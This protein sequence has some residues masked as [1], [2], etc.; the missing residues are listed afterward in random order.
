MNNAQSKR[1]AQFIN[2]RISL[3]EL[4]RSHGFEPKLDSGGRYK[5]KCPLPNHDEKTASFTIYDNNSYYCFGCAS[6]G[7]V[8]SFMME[9]GQL[10]YDQV[11]DQFRGDVDVDSDKFFADTIVKNLNKKSF[12]VF[13]Y[14]KDTQYQLGIYLRDMIYKS[15]EKLDK[16]NECFREM[17]MFFNNE[18]ITD[19]KLIDQFVDEIMERIK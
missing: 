11:I 7:N 17:D 15:P 1:I 2:K 18:S 5:M 4:I 14:K 13:K 10:T 9:Y 12:N 3:L 19:E 6:G 8:V 16:V